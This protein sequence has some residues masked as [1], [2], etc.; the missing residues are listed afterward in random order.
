MRETKHML[1]FH[2]LIALDAGLFSFDMKLRF[3][4]ISNNSFFSPK[5]IEIY[6][7]NRNHVK[8]GDKKKLAN[9]V[10]KWHDMEWELSG[11]SEKKVK[12]ILHKWMKSYCDSA[13]L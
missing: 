3:H 9:V 13:M 2:L 8:I 1:S 12:D 10:N 4:K 5:R 6:Y 11:F 7:I